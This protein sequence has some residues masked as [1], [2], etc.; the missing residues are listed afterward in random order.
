MLLLLVP[1]LETPAGLTLSVT[2]TAIYVEWSPVVDATEYIVI[3][4]KE[5]SPGLFKLVTVVGEESC[6]VG[7]LESSTRY[8][9]SIKAKNAMQDSTISKSTC[10]TTEKSSEKV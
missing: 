2:G 3:I 6:T 4:K 7:D 5:G 9:V 1:D 8:C 10:I